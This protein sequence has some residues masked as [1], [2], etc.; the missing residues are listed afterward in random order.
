[1]CLHKVCGCEPGLKYTFNLQATAL[2]YIPRISMPSAHSLKTDCLYGLRSASLCFSRQF[3]V[4]NLKGHTSTCIY[5]SVYSTHFHR[6]TCHQTQI[7]IRAVIKA[8]TGQFYINQF[9][10]NTIKK[11]LQAT[12]ID[13]MQV[14]IMYKQ[15]WVFLLPASLV[16][17][18][19]AVLPFHISIFFFFK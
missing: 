12:Q 11:S 15:L 5:A 16:L 13:Q 6:L 4:L 18:Y 14:Q 17:L 10:G 1:M 8:K 2:V 3:E 19:M 7:M 9:I